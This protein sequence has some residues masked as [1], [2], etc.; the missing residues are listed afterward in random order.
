MTRVIEASHRESDQAAPVALPTVVRSSKTS[1]QKSGKPAI[2][3]HYCSKLGHKAPDCRKKQQDQ[4][5]ASSATSKEKGKSKSREFGFS[6]CEIGSSVNSSKALS[7]WLIDSGAS[8]HITGDPHCFVDIQ[9]LQHPVIVRIANGKE[10]ISTKIGT[11]EIFHQ[12]D[13]ILVKNVHFIPDCKQNLLSCK[14]MLKDGKTLRMTKDACY[15]SDGTQELVVSAVN[16]LYYL[17]SPADVYTTIIDQPDS[18]RSLTLQEAHEI[19]GHVNMRTLRNM[20]KLRKLKWKIQDTP[21]VDKPCSGCLLGK[22]SRQI[23]KERIVKQE[24]SKAGDLVS[25]DL[26]GPAQVPSTN[27]NRYF[28]GKI[29][30]AIDYI[31]AGFLPRKSEA[32][33]DL[34]S[35]AN[36]LSNQKGIHIRRLRTDNAKEYTSNAFSNWTSNLGISHQFTTPYSSY[37]NGKEALV[38]NNT[39]EFVKYQPQFNVLPNQWIFSIKDNPDY[40]IRYKA[41]LVTGGHK[42]R[43]GIDFGQTFAPVVRYE[44]IRL[45]IALA[46]F[47]GWPI[48]QL[49]FITA[50]LNGLVDEDIYMRI[51]VGYTVPGG[52]SKGLCLETET[53]TLWP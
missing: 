48:H 46:T 24:Y 30:H 53:I 7:T 37:Q 13:K 52:G 51:P 40:S 42:Q 19:L 11:V 6:V 25:A 9:T 35:Y 3:C 43:E 31:H 47:F 12:G 18:T 33:P 44:S 50:F 14:Q 16:G 5:Q 15:I 10:L 45:L 39:W 20:I 23:P 26:W 28:Q 8:I 49:D 27:K 17:N 1:R 22:M 34:Q 21:G 36:L 41:R 38:S 29:D 4:A 32:L 2:I